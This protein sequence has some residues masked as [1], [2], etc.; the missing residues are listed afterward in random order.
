MTRY[1]VI[2]T[3]SLIILTLTSCKDQFSGIPLPKAESCTM[4]SNVA[5]C[6]DKRKPHGEQN[7]DKPFRKMIGYQCTNITDKNAMLNDIEDKRK[8]LAKLRRKTKRRRKR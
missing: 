4:L 5:A 2:S 1:F 6:T 8:E 7:Y 3:I